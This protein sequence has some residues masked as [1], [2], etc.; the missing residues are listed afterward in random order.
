MTESGLAD[1]MWSGLTKMRGEITWDKN[2]ICCVNDC[3]TGWL[4][5]LLPQ[6][7]R[8]FGRRVLDKVSDESMRSA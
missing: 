2:G 5:L 6:H 8:R 1:H 4:M 3:M 7:I